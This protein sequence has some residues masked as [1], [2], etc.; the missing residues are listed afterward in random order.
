VNGKKNELMR[1]IEKLLSDA[2]SQMP[3]GSRRCAW[4]L[5]ALILC[6]GRSLPCPGSSPP[7]PFTQE[8]IRTDAD[9][10]AD[11]QIKALTK[12]FSPTWQIGVM[13]AG[14]AD[15]SHISARGVIYTDALQKWATADKWGLQPTSKKGTPFSAD[16][17]CVGQA[18]L[19][20]E[21][22]DPNPSHLAPLIHRLDAFVDH[23]KAESADAKKITWWW[24]DTLFME[25]PV[26]ARLSA[27][28][29]NR[30][31]IDAMDTEYWRTIN[32]LFDH[33]RHLIFR[34][35]NFLKKLD[36]N[37]KPIFWARGNGW[38]IAGLARV[39]TY[40]PTDYPDRAKY[41]AL[42]KE[43]AGGL[44]PLQT[45]DG[46]WHASLL[47]PTLFNNPETS[48]T[49]LMTY[50]LAWGVN[51]H[52][53]DRA[54][55]QPALEKA[56]KALLADRQPN[57]LPGYSE[58]ASDRPKA[59]QPTDTQPYTTGAM[60]LAACELQKLAPSE[61]AGRGAMSVGE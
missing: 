27:M 36:D 41:E 4:A 19:D 1:R 25:P 55:Y 13:E 50:G 56:W 32:L 18:Y 24:C 33:Q 9:S 15:Y 61:V 5:A 10:L 11:A 43:F 45:D 46:T 49:A 47:D 54:T 23:I 16:Y 51:N 2:V 21:A 30:K 40:M 12:P 38:V 29:G 20:L 17:V 35:P 60:L 53:L 42:F 7:S 6:A 3:Q 39:L 28:T 37:G 14:Y 58:S 52:L 8:Q 44:L 48:G 57:G 26:L 59:A 31:Y 34:D 22:H